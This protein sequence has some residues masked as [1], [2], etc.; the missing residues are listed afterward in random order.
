VCANCRDLEQHA[1]ELKEHLRYLE[2]GLA[3][4]L[5]TDEACVSRFLCGGE[6]RFVP[7]LP[8]VTE[9]DEQLAN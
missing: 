6:G 8:A 3:H 4:A 1:T 5:K 2:D 7:Y 9:R